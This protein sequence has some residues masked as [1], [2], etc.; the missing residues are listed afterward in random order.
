MAT[1]L[2]TQFLKHSVKAHA[3]KDFTTINRSLSVGEAIDVVRQA[4]GGNG[5]QYYYVVDDSGKLLG[6]LPLRRLITYPVDKPVHEVMQS[7][8]VAIPEQATILDACEFFVLHKLLAFPVVNKQRL[9]VG[10][11]DVSQFT[12]EMIDLG[13]DTP[14]PVDD[15]FEA[16]G[17]RIARV[18]G[19]SPL[20]AFRFRFPWLIATIASGIGCAVLTS[21][22]EVTLAKSIILAFFLAL[23][24]GL[25]ESGS[26]Q[27]MTLT[28]Q[29][30]RSVKPT[31]RW[32][33]RELWR[34][35]RIACLLAGTSSLL[36]G[37]IVLG[38]THT[39]L[40][41]LVIACGVG[42]ALL[43]ACFFGLT[44]PTILH[45]LKLD[46]KIAAGPIT[47]AFTDVLTLV[48]YFGLAAM[49]LG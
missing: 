28:I 9:V 20:R 40:P 41:A 14:P 11:I 13:G 37:L 47:L 42:G 17:L 31:L 18:R 30:L 29:S 48:I 49:L 7:R 24:L 15:V 5:I 10:V 2:Q 25:G 39:V 19:A 35:M 22:F 38:W 36:V 34:E 4:S 46:P 21:V 45:A 26:I 23:V 12:T 33:G 16:I 44:V 6:V 32:Y 3:R 1:A 27:T 8:V 43:G